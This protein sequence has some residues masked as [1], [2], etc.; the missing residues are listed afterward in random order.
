MQSDKARNETIMVMRAANHTFR[1]IGKA[2]GV[3]P[4]RAHQIVKRI[5]RQNPTDGIEK[6]S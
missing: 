6:V 2:L 1:E 4:Q 5:E 3:S